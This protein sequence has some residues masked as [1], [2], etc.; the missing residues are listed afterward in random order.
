MES[1]KV[2]IIP[3]DEKSK[4][5]SQVLAN[6]TSRRV[7]DLISEE[8]MS[9]MKIA[10]RLNM[11]INTAQYNLERLE[12]V[13]M[14]EVLRVEKSRKG[15]DVKIYAPTNRIIAIVPK[16]MDIGGLREAFRS[17]LPLV[18]AA[19]VISVGV[20]MFAYPQG[21]GYA[22]YGYSAS[23]AQAKA[24][25]A[26]TGAGAADDMAMPM[27][28]NA[29]SDGLMLAAPMPGNYTAANA[30]TAGQ[31]TAGT[32][33]GVGE[34]NLPAA[35]PSASNGSNGSNGS[36]SEKPAAGENRTVALGEGPGDAPV[37]IRG[38]PEY[39]PETVQYYQGPRSLLEHPGLW[40]LLGGLAV[41]IVFAAV[42]RKN[43]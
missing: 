31:L 40:T 20:E 36:L 5:V 16:N 41:I 7:L 23:A 14:V 28:A 27:A 25:Y 37:S 17:I 3:L 9:A 18:I 35:P 26:A 12:S 43:I 39:E 42:R 8:P 4:G 19:L 13:G 24:G 1:R 34:N 29:E 32:G 10:Y 22:D 21:P 38:A 30:E 2:A 6:D 11:G 33:G 15:R